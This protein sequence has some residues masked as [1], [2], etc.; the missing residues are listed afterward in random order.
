MKHLSIPL[1]CFCL[2]AWSCNNE[3]YLDGVHVVEGFEVDIAAGPDLVEFPMFATFDQTGRLF[4]FES[5]G[6]VYKENEDAINNPQFRIKVLEDVDGDGL[7]DKSTLFADSLSYTQGGVFYDGSLIISSSPD[8]IKLTDTDGDGRAD[9]REV[10]LTGWHLNINANSLIGPF[11]GPDDYLYLTSACMGFDVVS[12]EGKHFKGETSRVWRLRPDGSDLQ[13]VSAGGMNNLIEITFTRAGEAIGTQTFYVSPQR[14]LRD[15]IV[16]WTE[17]GVYGK[18]HP[19]IDRDGLPR[20]GQ[21]LP[22][23]SEYSRVAPSGIGT[24]RNSVFGDDYKGNIFSTQFNTRSVI[25]HRPIRKD[26]SFAFE[27]ENFFWSNDSD[28]HPTD[29]LEDASGGLLVVE[30]GGWFIKGCPLSGM[31]KPKLKGAIYRIRRKDTPNVQDA[32]GNKIDWKNET[33]IELIEHLSDSR[34]FVSERASGFLAL[35]NDMPIEDLKRLLDSEVSKDVKTQAIFVL[36]RIGSAKAIEHIRSAVEGD[37]IQVRLAAIRCLGMKRDLLSVSLLLP[38]LTDPHPAIVRQAATSLGQIGALTAIPDLLMALEK[39]KDR[40]AEHAI[41]YALIHMDQPQHLIRALRN[42]NTSNRKSI[43]LALDQ[44][45][46]SPLQPSDILK[47]LGEDAIDWKETALAVASRHPE[48]AEEMSDYILETGLEGLQMIDPEILQ[49]LFVNYF[50]H[51]SIHSALENF[52][53]NNDSKS[54][55]FALDIL[56]KSAETNMKEWE[57]RLSVLLSKKNEVVIDKVIRLLEIRKSDL[58]Q[59]ELFQVQD[60]ESLSDEIRISALKTAILPGSQLTG[61]HFKY[62]LGILK[63]DGQISLHFDIADLFNNIELSDHQLSQILNEFLANSKPVVVNQFLSLYKGART[64]ATRKKLYNIIQQN[65]SLD[66]FH[67]N[68]LISLFSSFG[69]DMETELQQIKNQLEVSNS[70]RLQR[71]EELEQLAELGNIENGRKL[72]FGKG[73]CSTCHTI[74]NSGF[75]FGPDLTAIQ[76]DRTKHDIVESILYPSAS[77][78]RD[79]ETYRVEL[80]NEELSGILLDR[81]TQYTS[82]KT[83]ANT[84]YKFANDDIKSIEVTDRSLMPQGI[85]ELL[86]QEELVDLISFL[87]GTDLVYNFKK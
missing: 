56:E 51:P 11:L 4:V 21:L 30:T 63:G 73:I 85:S 49:S 8:L 48:W 46:S 52:L 23:V 2:L 6:D 5:A 45:T 69:P 78:I 44:M 15:A 60:D 67:E 62:S 59:T 71:V 47:I 35:H 61:A 57:K 20:T 50:G 70:E 22:V 55:I 84:I 86:T 41:I 39:V 18:E 68:E 76:H 25:R 58:L 74:G 13:W 66:Q 53:A 77:L 54:Q 79:Y 17:G 81:T 43:L 80:E 82:I 75:D 7:F 26:G 14:G 38:C 3:R 33:V 72:Y 27:D 83:N 16:Y 36:N 65:A 19:S 10:I 24:Y 1:Y 34:P 40:M 9:K 28:F 87:M 12:K 42:Q 29:V 37:Y 64:S 31:S 32:Y